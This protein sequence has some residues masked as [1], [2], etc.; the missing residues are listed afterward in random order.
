MTIL[1]PKD[2]PIVTAENQLGNAESQLW[3]HLVNTHGSPR[4]SAFGVRCWKIPPP[5]S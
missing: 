1:M 5:D 4:Y 2:I 3:R